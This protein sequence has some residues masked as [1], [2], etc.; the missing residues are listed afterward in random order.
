MNYLGE[1]ALVDHNSPISNSGLIFYETLYDENAACHLALGNGFKECI[2]DG[3]DLP[4]TELEK[5]GYNKSD[6]HVDFM[7]GTSDL[8]IIGTTYDNKEI[9]IFENGN[10][11]QNNLL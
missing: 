4:E 1:V 3:I 9:T 6:G 5:L 7:I 10:F 8:K 11:C 2:K